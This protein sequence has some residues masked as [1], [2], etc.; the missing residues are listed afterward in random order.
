MKVRINGKVRS[1]N[2]FKEE[3]ESQYDDYD[4][5]SAEYRGIR[6]R[7]RKAKEDLLESD[8]EFPSHVL[9]DFDGKTYL[10]DSFV[11]ETELEYKIHKE[12]Q[13]MDDNLMPAPEYAR[14]EKKV[15]R[16]LRKYI[17]EK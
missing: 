4:K 16:L 7:F 6:V 11:G 5:R 12:L 17:N 2:E 14:R 15:N 13:A 1:Y 3:I 8:D 9:E 10:I